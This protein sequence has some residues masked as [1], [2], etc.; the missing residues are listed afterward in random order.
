[1]NPKWAHTLVLIFIPNSGGHTMTRTPPT[2]SGERPLP[3]LSRAKANSNS[4][5]QLGYKDIRYVNG[6]PASAHL[7]M[8]IRGLGEA[9]Q[10]ILV[11]KPPSDTFRYGK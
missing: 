5:Q 1:M 11:R 6:D 10:K 4:G 2:T 3:P 7:N 8:V 9:P